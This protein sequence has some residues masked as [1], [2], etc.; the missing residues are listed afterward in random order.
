M[1]LSFHPEVKA[2]LCDQYEYYHAIDSELG[3]SFIS[4]YLKALAF[5][6]RQPLV[7]RI[8]YKNDRRVHLK[9]FKSCALFTMCLK[10]KYE[11][12]R[13]QIFVVSLTTGLHAEFGFFN[14]LAAV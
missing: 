13:S 4:E 7:M 1:K 3:L 10:M 12:K 2:D 9:R 8:F 14:C 5:V 6:K 11:L